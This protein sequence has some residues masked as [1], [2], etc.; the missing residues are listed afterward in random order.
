MWTR[1][2]LAWGLLFGL[3]AAVPRDDY[4][5]AAR[6]V[7]FR[8]LPEYMRFGDMKT[9]PIIWKRCRELNAF[10]SF[11]DRNVILCYELLDL[12]VAQET[13]DGLIR[14]FLAHELAHAA[15]HQLDVPIV[16]SPEVAA[17]ELATLV[18]LILGYEDDLKVI[19][20]L[21]DANRDPMVDYD[22]HL[23]AWQ[24]RF[25]VLCLAAGKEDRPVYACNWKWRQ[26]YG[27]WHRL[28]G[29]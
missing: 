25:N 15:I 8:G 6:A 26:A 23:H 11:Q 7:D 9:V 1:L 17:D 14:Y 28:I 12:P 16:G 10:Y 22:Q 20:D 27:S 4:P 29:L 13:R 3:M 5:A 2:L 24:R 19:V 21:W 18:L